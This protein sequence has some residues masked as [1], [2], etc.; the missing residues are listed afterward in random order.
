LAQRSWW[1]RAVLCILFGAVVTP[2]CFQFSGHLALYP[3]LATFALILEGKSPSFCLLY[4]ALRFVRQA[5]WC[6]PFG[7][8]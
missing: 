8:L 2:T 4:G 5:L 6:L 3:A 7:L 1:W